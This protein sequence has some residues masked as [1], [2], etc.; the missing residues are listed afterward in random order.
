MPP[1]LEGYLIIGLTKVTQL[2]PKIRA[3]LGKLTGRVGNI[4]HDP[5]V[6]FAFS[7]PTENIVDALERKLL[8]RCLHLAFGGKSQRF[9]KIFSR[10]DDRT[11]ESVA[12]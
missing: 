1:R 12:T 11:S 6:Y 2:G 5:A 4:Y 10:S 7:Q 8:D 3:P 9:L